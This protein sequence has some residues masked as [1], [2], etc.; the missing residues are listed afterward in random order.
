MGNMQYQDLTTLLYNAAY[1]IIGQGTY[2]H[3]GKLD[4]SQSSIA[5]PFPHLN[6]F[7]PTDVTPDA[8]Q[9]V[10]T[11]R[12]LF[13]A[14][15]KEPADAS[16]EQK[17]AILASMDLLIQKFITSLDSNDMIVVSGIR[18]EPQPVSYAARASGYA[19]ELLITGHLQD[20]ACL[21]A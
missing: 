3:A 12:I 19:A 5:E 16:P 18:R 2:T 6:T 14:L 21:P 11:Y 9:A 8:A 4:Y 7:L 17:S 20:N 13:I 1:P 15:D 10:R